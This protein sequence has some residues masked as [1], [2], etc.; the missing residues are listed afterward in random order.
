MTFLTIESD[1]GKVK[2]KLLENHFTEK[3]IPFLKVMFETFE[4]EFRSGPSLGYTRSK[5]LPYIRE[6]AKRLVDSVDELNAMGYNYPY[7]VQLDSFD[8]CDLAGQELLNKLH[9]SFTTA[10]RDHYQHPPKF[11]W[12]DRFDSEFTVDPKDLDR[13]LYLTE[14]LNNAVHNTEHYMMT[15][16]KTTNFGE[17]IQQV[18]VKSLVTNEIS[19]VHTDKGPYETLSG[20]FQKYTEE[21]Y[22]LFSDSDEYDVWVGRD[23]LGKDFIHAFYDY[24]DPT[25]WDVTGQLGYSGKIAM[26]VGTVTKSMVI[27]SDNFKQWLDK[28]N[29]PYSKKM[30]GMPL[31]TVIEG[32]DL[33]RA[34]YG[35]SGTTNIKVSFE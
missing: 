4:K 31:G 14:T 19:K 11:V 15:P 23:I 16:Y 6:Q 35:K 13:M 5:N 7:Q 22:E 32:K 17:V 2:I 9:R 34:F 20:W 21:D 33:L 26:D 25:N 30:G 18:E 27:K 1:L 29:V 3:Y 10:Q 28:Y 24:D 12:S 8:N